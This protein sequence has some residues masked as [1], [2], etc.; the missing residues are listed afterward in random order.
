LGFVSELEA[1][2]ICQ[3]PVN[4]NL[5]PTQN[6]PSLTALLPLKQSHIAQ[7]PAL[8]KTSGF[9]R[10]GAEFSKAHSS[11]LLKTSLPCLKPL[12][13][14]EALPSLFWMIFKV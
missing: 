1:I 8:L 3:Y 5:E 2:H 4:P 11:A 10:G 6:F 14:G 9:K 7:M 13:L 12:V